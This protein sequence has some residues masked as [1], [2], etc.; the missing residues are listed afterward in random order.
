MISLVFLATRINFIDRLTISV[1]AP[2]ITT[3]L[4]LTNLQ[5]AGISTWF[6]IAYTASQGLSGDL[7]KPCQVMCA[8][9]GRDLVHGVGNGDSTPQPG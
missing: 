1:P 7:G 6:L 9:N 8:Q 3:Q 2:V 4:G 5:F